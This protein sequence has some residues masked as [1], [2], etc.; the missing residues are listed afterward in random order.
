MSVKTGVYVFACAWNARPMDITAARTVECFIVFY[1]TFANCATMI[2]NSAHPRPTLM[3]EKNQFYRI[4]FI[5]LQKASG[6][7]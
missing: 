6:E 2:P 5:S 4:A 7:R 3:D 1:P